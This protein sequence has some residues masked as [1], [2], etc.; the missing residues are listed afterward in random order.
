MKEFELLSFRDSEMVTDFA[1][2]VDRLTAFLGDHREVLG[3][4]RVVR[5]VL[6]SVPRWLKQLAVSIEIHGD[7]DA[8]TL[9]ELIGQLQVTE[10]TDAE[11]EPATKGGSG[12]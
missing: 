11:D 4:S 10:D 9:D 7:L 2:R 8:M 5:K 6:R 1:M 12:E 3:I